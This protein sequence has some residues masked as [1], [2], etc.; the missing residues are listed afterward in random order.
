[1][2]EYSKKINVI[3][4]LL[5]TYDFGAPVWRL[6]PDTTADRLGVEVRDADLLLT[7]FYTL[8]AEQHVLHKLPLSA[9]K[10]W[11]LGLEDAHDGLLFLHGY[12]DR[13]IGEHKG[14][15]AYDAAGGKLVWEQPELAY[16]GINS[17]GV[18]ALDLKQK[19]LLQLQS[20][21]GTITMQNVSLE[22]GAAAVANY[23]NTRFQNCITPMLYLEGET[24]FAEV[25]DFLEQ[26]LQLQAVRGIEYAETDTC[27]VISFY[28][29]T[30]DGKLDN[31][32][33]VFDL[34]GE[35]QLNTRIAL[36]ISGI[37]SDTFIIFNKKLYFIQDRNILTVYSLL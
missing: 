35:L 23:S 6:R 16:Y 4:P 11:W 13:Q 19:N 34:S 28:I 24:Y 21:T 12:G 33:S 20:D 32:L 5:Y 14:I 10:N 30:P 2:P 9:T 31:V 3:L 29:S 37:G 25:A 27:I 7:D 22:S 17:D 36:G 8:C 1:M 15:F 18:L 26:Q